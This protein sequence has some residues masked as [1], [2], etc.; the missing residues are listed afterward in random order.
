L[1]GQSSYEGTHRYLKKDQYFWA[2]TQK[3]LVWKGS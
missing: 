2:K 1:L 3:I